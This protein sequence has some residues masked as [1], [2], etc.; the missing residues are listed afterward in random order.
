MMSVSRRQMG[1]LPCPAPIVCLDKHLMDQLLPYY[2]TPDIDCGVRVAQTIG[3]GE[4]Y[5]YM[6]SQKLSRRKERKECY[7]GEIF[8]M[9]I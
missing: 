5:R 6:E 2:F 8:T 7:A 9:Q 3:T 1:W 4:I